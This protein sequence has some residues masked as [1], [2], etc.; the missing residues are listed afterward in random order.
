MPVKGAYLAVAGAGAIFLWSGLKG[1]SWSQVIRALI[2]G[3]NPATL[4]STNAIGTIGSGNP[5]ANG[6]VPG[7][8]QGNANGSAIANDALGY[9]GHPYSFGGAP[10]ASGQNPWD[11]SSFVNWVLNH[12]MVSPIPGYSGRGWNPSTHG[13]N[14]LSYLAWPGARTISRANVAAGNLCVWETHMGIAINN[15]QMISALNPSL[16][17][18]VTGIENGGPRGQVLICKAVGRTL[19]R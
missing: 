19:C 2:S 16:G 15:T 17:T 3:Q 11:C 9:Q 18:E 5:S 12:D 1:K 7:A 6:E 10:G 8:V 4:T 13:P 14:T